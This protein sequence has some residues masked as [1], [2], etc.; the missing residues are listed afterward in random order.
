MFVF[1]RQRNETVQAVELT[2][3]TSDAGLTAYPALSRDGRMLAY[4]SDRAGGI[5]NIW[6]RQVGVGDAVRITTGPV[7]DT[8]PSFSPDG[9]MIAFRSE[10][11]GGGIYIVPALGGA[12]R[13]MADQG[14]SPRFSPDGQ[15]IAYWVGEEHQFASNAVYIVPSTG[16]ESR[17]L[18]STFF[19]AYAPL[20]SRDGRHVLFLGAEDDKKP[21]AE[22]YDWWVAPVNGGS[23]VATGAL[24]AL[25]TKGVFPV[26]RR[27]GDWV[28]DSVLFAASTAQYA[29]VL[30]TGDV[31]QS[32][33]W[34]VHLAPNS[35]RIEGDP[36]QLTVATGVEAQPSMA[37]A[38]DGAARLAL[39]N[40]RGNMEVWAVP[41][42]ANEGRVTGDTQRITTTVVDNTYP[43]VSS[44]GSRLVFVSDRQRN[45]DVLMMDLRTG[46]ETALTATEVNEFSP[47][48]SADN[49]KVL[50]YV[51]RPALKPSFSFWVVSATGGVPRQVCADCDGPLYGWSSDT[52]KVIYRD[53][54]P[55]RPGRVRARYI[56][57][58]RDD[59]LVEHPKYAITFPRLSADERWILFQTVI[60]QTQ[61]GIFVAPL[62]DWHAAPESSWIPIT[63][64]HTPDR[65][66]V[67]SPD[68][69]L[70]Y[71]LSERDGFR[72]F[73]AQRV[74]AT[75]KRPRGDPFVVQHF[76]QARRGF[77]PD[78]F[79]GLPLSVGPD[80]LVFQMRERTGNI[81]LATIHVR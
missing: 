5:M 50:Y 48:L 81:W 31:N 28:G 61:R 42:Q 34:S 57:S 60:T 79:S 53:N 3:V 16:G 68:G 54:P 29:S 13:R 73:W 7:D 22:R 63:N 47:F 8:E 30:S 71:F 51:F 37:L 65:M 36:R 74:D 26:S 38:A 55:D 75:T 23:P 64:G 40:T 72:C 14:R 21:V 17:R 69:N 76:H 80:K 43:S 27:P 12:E 33:I 62:R 10:R 39:A 1:I 44:D 6:V 15:S 49:S 77:L 20:W 18:A 4:A 41:V 58:S 56:D 66:A 59:V 67:W 70:V 45:T 78:D 35:W 32:S 52:Q 9:T 2:R 11:D 46:V 25:R 19:S 24:A